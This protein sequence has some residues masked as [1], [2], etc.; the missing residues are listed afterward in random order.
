MPYGTFVK[1]EQG[2]FW[3]VDESVARE[4]IGCILRD[5][6]HTQYKSSTK[7]KVAK[8]QAMKTNTDTFH[9]WHLDN[10]MQGCSGPLHNDSLQGVMTTK[11]PTQVGGPSSNFGVKASHFPRATEDETPF[12][13][14]VR[15]SDDSSMMESIFMAANT[16]TA[17]STRFFCDISPMSAH[18]EIM[19]GANSGAATP[20]GIM[21][22]LEQACGAV[23][24]IAM[25]NEQ[26]TSPESPE[27]LDGM[28]S[29]DVDD[30]MLSLI[31]FFPSS[32]DPATFF[33]DV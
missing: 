32:F 27:L 20:R 2:R 8:R 3:E 23:S 6:L 18:Q 30:D 13:E 28:S 12:E 21:D 16:Y 1:K 9:K 33:D 26:W 7:A 24:N 5:W 10:W 19:T 14:Q 4:K 17:K 31:D 29:I 15:V 22:A 25:L 11:Q